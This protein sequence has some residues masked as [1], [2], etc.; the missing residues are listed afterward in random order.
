MKKVANKLEIEL[1]IDGVG[2]VNYNGDKAHTRFLRDMMVNGKVTKNGTFAKENS[3]RTIIIDSDNNEKK[4]EVN[5]KIISGNLLRKEILGDENSVNADKLCKYDE[6]RVMYLS[7][8]NTI[9]RGYGVFDKDQTQIKRKSAISVIDAEQTSN[10]VTWL[11]TKT[12]EGS[13][14][15]T[16]LFFKENCGAI[17]YKSDINVNVRQLQFISI[18]DN[19]DRL[20]MT[21][22]DVNGFI[23]IINKRYGD[24]N[25]EY[26]NW[27]TSNLNLIG[28]QGIVLSN[29][30]VTNIIRETIKKILSIDV[31]RASSYAKTAGVRVAIGYAGDSIDLLAKPNFET[32][33]SISD[34]DKIV[35]NI[36]FGVTFLPIE[37]PLIVKQEKKPK[38]KEKTSDESK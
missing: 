38:T 30:V 23:E 9:A 20:S 36:E 2:L 5:K 7:Q 26:G 15:D 31:R 19:Y 21:E 17:S 22:K 12:A 28:E 29:K 24:N 32:I 13:R 16:S 1:V 8:D 33:N 10:T 6:L 37:T 34:Y 35:E 18:D 3:Y 11:E 4:I 25:A 14:D 27:G